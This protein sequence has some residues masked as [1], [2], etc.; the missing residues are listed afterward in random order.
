VVNDLQEQVSAF[1]A[2]VEQ[3]FPT[4]SPRDS[5]A[6]IVTEAGEL[7]DAMLKSGYADAE[8]L[9]NRPQ[10]KDLE[11]ELGDLLFMTITL[12]NSLGLDVD[13]A[14]LKSMAKIQCRVIKR[15]Q[16]EMEPPSF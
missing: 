4:P 2:Q 9:R 11:T 6:F 7:L 12:A 8:Y 13:R 1:R 14:L 3:W 5:M 10:E 16:A 15:Q